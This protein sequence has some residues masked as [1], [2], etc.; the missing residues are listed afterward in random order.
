MNNKSP[1]PREAA[2]A[3]AYL[4]ARE[5]LD[6][7]TGKTRATI[8][9]NPP[10]VRCGNRCIPPTW[11]CRL[12]G[13]GNDPHLAAK[14]TDPVGGLAN[15]ERGVKRLGKFARTGSFSELESSKRSL[16]RGAVK[17]KPGT[18]KEKDE[19][20][21]WIEQN[22]SRIA[23]PVTIAGVGLFAHAGLKSG[24]V[25]GYREGA[26]AKIDR[27]VHTGI[28]AVLDVVPGVGQAR[29]YTR[30]RAAEATAFNLERVSMRTQRKRSL[31]N[32]E[33]GIPGTPIPPTWKT[34]GGSD[35]NSGLLEID[36]ATKASDAEALKRKSTFYDWNTN[37]NLAFWEATHPSSGKSVFAEPSAKAFL[38]DEWRLNLPANADASAYRVALANR[39]ASESDTFI[40]LAK[41]QGF[42]AYGTPGEQYLRNEDIDAFIVR[43]TRGM[44]PELASAHGAF[45]RTAVKRG[46]NKTK[47]NVIYAGNVRFYDEYFKKRVVP[48]LKN[49]AGA[50]GLDRDMRGEGAISL[51]AAAN[52]RR[53]HFLIQTSNKPNRASA[54]ISHDELFML[55][56]YHTKVVGDTKSPYTINTRLAVTAASE[57]SG[58]TKLTP[59]EAIELLNTTYGFP[60]A[61]LEQRRTTRRASDAQRIAAM[62]RRK[63]PDGTPVFATREAAE[64]ELRRQDAEELPP[65]VRAYLE[66]QARLDKRCGKSGIPEGRKCTKNTPAQSPEAARRAKGLAEPGLTC[67]PPN[68]KCGNLCIP[69]TA[70]CHLKAG[71]DALSTAAKVA[72]IAGGAAAVYGVVKNRKRIGAAARRSTIQAR[73]NLRNT[74][75]QAYRN[76]VVR[77][78]ASRRV[79]SNVVRTQTDRTVSEL[80]KRTI[81]TLSRADVDTGISRLPKNFQEPVRRLVG[82]AKLSAAHLALKAKGGR[83]TSVNNTDNFS[84]WEMKDGTLLSTGSVDDTLIIYNTKPQES[85]GGARTYATQFRVDGEFDAKSPAA[86][87]NSR[88]VASTVKK[89]FRSQ[90]E[91]VPDNSIITAIPYSGDTKGKKR[92]S[93][94]EMAGFR[95]ALSSD[96]RL[97]AMKTKG[98]FT[99][100]SDNHVEQIADLIRNDALTLDA[101]DKITPRTSRFDFTPAAQRQGK[102]CGKS[103]IPKNQNCSKT[104]TA[105]Y[106]SQSNN[107]SE[108]P[109]LAQKVGVGAAALTTAG[110]VAGL[111]TIASNKKKVSAYRN[112]VSKS[113]V[114]AEKLAIEYERQFREQAAQRLKKRPQDVTGFEASV[115]NYNDKGFDR[116]FGAFESDAKWFG[117][118]K[119]SKGA[120]VMLSYA[121]AKGKGG[122][123]MANGGAFQSVWGERDILPYANN[124]SQPKASNDLDH[125]QQLARE[126]TMKQAERVAGPLGKGLA[127]GA[128]TTQ[129]ALKRFEFLRKNVNERGFN[130]D[131]V[132]AAA[133]VVAQRRLTGKPVDIMSYSNGGNVA[134]E[135]LAILSEMGYRDVKVVNVAGPTFGIFNHSDDN[136]RTWVSEG[137]EFYK[138]SNGQ[139][140]VGGNTRMLKNKNIPHG[141]RDG[142]DPNN[143]ETGAT[144]RQNMKDKKSY[145]LDEQLQQEAYQ[146]LTVDNKRANELVNEVI[147]RVGEDM[148]F[149]G[150]LGTLFGSNSTVAKS[151]FKGF[152]ASMPRDQARQQIKA[153]LEGRMLDVWYGG[154]NPKQVKNAQKAIRQELLTY[155][156]PSR[157]AQARPPRPASLSQRIERLMEQ[158]PGMSREAARR[159]AQEQMR[160]PTKTDAYDLACALTLQRLCAA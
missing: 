89:M 101:K 74:N 11:D 81:K 70:T 109:T 117:Q 54:G 134:T 58:R 116:G 24:N 104:T 45:L 79:A 76:T 8:Q 50:P 139:A 12:K 42:R 53:T 56:Y 108:G 125:M 14:R 63:N 154:Y 31:L 61:R 67:F 5:R 35:L 136:M 82:D 150:D 68:Q 37:H 84:N 138:Y 83:I 147:W 13:Q 60:T 55:D 121:D 94:Y 15:I 28:G 86:S 49:V 159:R 38:N 1:S 160:R 9:C 113:A 92:R 119:Q 91:Q 52:R 6:F 148:K 127:K 149:E 129:D 19:F 128:F 123:E 97:F 3:A 132:R 155:T 43:N 47:A 103:F 73:R 34:S 141:L 85:I 115:Y 39:I 98:K 17:L 152:L 78:R 66:M 99:R 131:A 75:R 65:R 51:R 111:V 145:L 151:R 124:I 96:E 135:T 72:S 143:R 110:A 120:V 22:W 26:G 4:A 36:N 7:R 100:M 71:G 2:R 133:F 107:K 41:Q 62:M 57:L 59:A 87:R 122:F 118:T 142:I 105:K 102:P 158:N 25:F 88:K 20:K 69:P 112:R 40:Q 10:N 95:Q 16:V 33:A 137:D 46:S 153:E 30:R 157:P 144:W 114:E 64:A 27:A 80:S 18:L 146:Y 48:N 23:I 32:P 44:P 21:A 29:A 77:A 93:I 106:A 130:P 156:T 90:M 140:F 126:R